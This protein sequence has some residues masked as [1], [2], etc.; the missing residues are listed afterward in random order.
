M[1]EEASFSPSFKHCRRGRRRHI[2]ADI[3][4]TSGCSL[5][6]TYLS[7]QLWCLDGQLPLQ[8]HR[9]SFITYMNVKLIKI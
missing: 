7:N 6:S 8:T 4:K 9:N 2:P 5:Y 3:A 1:A